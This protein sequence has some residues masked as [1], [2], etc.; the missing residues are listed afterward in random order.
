MLP[1]A[2]DGT[3]TER[4]WSGHT[5]VR[6]HRRGE[7]WSVWRW[8]DGVRWADDWY[9]NLEAPWRRSPI[10]FDT[11]DWVLDLVGAGDPVRG[12]WSVTFKDED[13]LAWM[14]EKGLVTTAQA[15]GVRRSGEQLMDS[16]MAGRWPFDAD[17]DAWLPDPAWARVPLPAHWDHL[18]R[19]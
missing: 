15:A 18:G 14:V 16:A 8:H 7:R 2:W 4:A 17:W 9:G 10:G 11:Q 6:V 3:Y 12:P 5:V 19:E 1:H 13:E